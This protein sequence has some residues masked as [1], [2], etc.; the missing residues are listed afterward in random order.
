MK[1]SKP[2][3]NPNAQ[4]ARDGNTI[5]NILLIQN[6]YSDAQEIQERRELNDGVLYSDWGICSHMCGCCPLRV[7]Q[8]QEE[9][10]PDA[11]H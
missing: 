4:R 7:A 9:F 8:S 3:S 11:G 10:L 5:L 2:T 6:V 1:D